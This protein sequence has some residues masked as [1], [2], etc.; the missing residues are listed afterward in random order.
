MGAGPNQGF[1]L[2]ELMQDYALRRYTDETPM[3]SHLVKRLKE[4]SEKPC[5]RLR[6]VTMNELIRCFGL[7]DRP[8]L[9]KALYARL[10]RCFDSNEAP[11]ARIVWKVAR[12]AH[13]KDHP[14]RWFAR[15]IICELEQ[16]DLI[17]DESDA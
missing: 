7:G 13:Q 14:D 12:R 8:R 10:V 16:R 17:V 11:V 6:P 4:I 3:H 5:H 1:N 9:R 2:G 15:V